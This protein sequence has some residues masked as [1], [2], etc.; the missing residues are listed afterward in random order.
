MNPL[1]PPAPFESSTAV[2]RRLYYKEETGSTQADLREL[3]LRGAKD[4]TVVVADYQNAGR[5]RGSNKWLA[6]K[7][8]CLLFSWLA[9]FPAPMSFASRFTMLS[10]LA[11]ADALG[12]IGVEAGIKWPNDLTVGDRKICGILTEMVADGNKVDFA[13]I[14]IG[15]NVN[16]VEEDLPN[17]LRRMATSVAMEIGGESDR[18]ALLA[19]VL[20]NIDERYA[21]L[22][23]GWNPVQE[24]KRRMITLGEV[25]CV[26][27]G[28]DRICGTA[29]D[30]GEH[31]ELVLRKPDGDSVEV[32]SG[33]V[34]VVRL[35][36]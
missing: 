28:G 13:L 26:N 5:G 31:G 25:V 4:G 17:E 32:W 16:L 8:C 36:A 19:E 15:L 7:G 24:W 3:A 33:L 2:G 35:R 6:P 22:K 21:A 30:V 14:G 9:R 1:W 10:A 34:E 23:S 29:E 12:A 11:V 20:G 18:G 27:V